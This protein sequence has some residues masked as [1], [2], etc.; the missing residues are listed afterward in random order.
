MELIEYTEQEL[1]DIAIETIKYG[2]E[3]YHPYYK[4]TV[5]KAR[6]CEQVMTGD[7][8][9]DLLISYKERET[10]KQKQQ[11]IKLTNSRT[12]FACGKIWSV[13]SEVSRTDNVVE[14]MKYENESDQGNNKLTEIEER[15]KKFYGS[16]DAIQYCYEALRRLNFYDPNAFLVINFTPF[17]NTKQKTDFVY[18]VEVYSEQA[19]RYEYSNGVL[20]YLFFYQDF[21]YD[22]QDENGKTITKMAKRYFMYAKDVAFEFEEVPDDSIEELRPGYDL[23]TIDVANNTEINQGGEPKTFQWAK[24]ELKSKQIPVVRAGYIPNSASKRAI[25]DSPLQPAEKLLYDLIWTKSE[26]DLAKALHWFYQKFIYAPPCDFESQREDVGYCE[27]GMMSISGEKC[28]SCN[29]TGLQIHKTVQDVIAV[30]LPSDSADIVPLSNMVHYENIDIEIGKHLQEDYREIEK[31]IF[32]AVFN[33]QAF[34]RSEVAVTATEKNLDLRAIKNALIDFADHV[35]RVYKFIIKQT[36]IYLDN[37]ENLIIQHKHQRDFKFED[38]QDLVAQRKEAVDAGSPYEVIRNIDLAI[39]ELQHLDDPEVAQMMRAKERFRPFREKSESERMYI[40][41][42][43]AADDYYRVLWTFFEEIMSEI[44]A[45][46]KSNKT[47]WYKLPYE[48]QKKVIDAKVEERQTEIKAE[49]EERAKLMSFG[50]PFAT[51]EEDEEENP[52]D[53]GQEE[54]AA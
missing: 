37:D 14:V 42:Q 20:I 26:Y 45:E 8:Q 5:K 27:N 9:D 2:K 18:P 13:F 32:K 12:Q 10:G 31:D 48:Q 34:D 25:F 47:P 30:R 29:G 7:D 11:R 44:W 54:T 36:A 52:D 1:F 50:S 49:Q 38:V 51:Q 15:L 6:F 41:T 28:P 21:E 33:S 19:I 23:I 22:T 43:L 40:L 4:E 17:D 16:Q 53:A 35:S 46:D 3:K 39:I 24:Y